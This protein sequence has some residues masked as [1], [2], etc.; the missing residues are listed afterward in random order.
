MNLYGKIALLRLTQVVY[1]ISLNFEIYDQNCT[2]DTLQLLLKI[3][4]SIGR[5]DNNK[6][7]DSISTQLNQFKL[8]IALFYDIYAYLS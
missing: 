4:V 6:D 1:Y 2:R 3:Q 5:L 7:Q 8:L